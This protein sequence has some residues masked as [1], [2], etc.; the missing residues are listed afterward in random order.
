MK[1][2]FGFGIMKEIRNRGKIMRSLK[3]LLNKC[4]KELDAL[5]I[6]YG[7]IH[8]IEYAD[9]GKCLGKCIAYYE[10][11]FDIQIS[12]LF[13]NCEADILDLKAIIMHELL[14]TCDGCNNHGELWRKYAALVDSA[15]H[16]DVLGFR[17]RRQVFLK[18]KEKEIIHR[19]V[20]PNCGGFWNI[21]DE[22]LWE[23][24]LRD[25]DYECSWCE[26]KCAIEY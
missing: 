11:V 19:L 10:E 8:K 21:R 5:N 13:K 14:H 16:Y 20:C 6:P 15:Y 9:V 1:T 3:I 25:E 4:M 17:T 7:N 24:I 2:F 22:K 26:G 18:E 12:E 23:K